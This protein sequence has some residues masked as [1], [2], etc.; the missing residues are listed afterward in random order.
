[1][2]TKAFTEQLEPLLGPDNDIP[3]P[4]M[5]TSS[6][7]MAWI[8]DQFSKDNGY[9]PDVVTGK[10]LVLGGSP[11]RTEATGYGAIMI[12]LRAAQAHGIDMRGATVAI[13][14]FGNVG[15]HA[16]QAGA[17][18]GAKVLAVSDKDGGIYHG[19]GLDVDKL[20]EATADPQNIPAVVDIDVPAD[21]ISNADLL[22]LKADILI[23]AA[24]EGAITNDNADRVRA[25]LVVEAANLPTTL[26]GDRILYDRGIRVAPDILTNAGGVTVSYFEWVQ[27]RQRYCWQRSKVD[28]R[29]EAVLDEAWR[30]VQKMAKEQELSCREAAYTLAVQRVNHAIELRGF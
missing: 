6:R 14:G 25:S 11:G 17:A 19:N 13:Q 8:F 10:P 28:E 2:L 16:A 4:D 12:A 26:E 5:G 3:A 30:D 1:V 9:T 22:E 20:F 18:A 24:V 21:A 27:N 15:R 7:E 23:P 29:L